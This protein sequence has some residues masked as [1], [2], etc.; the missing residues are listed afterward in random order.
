[1]AGYGIKIIH[2]FYQETDKKLMSIS[3]G[4]NESNDF[5]LMMIPHIFDLDFF[6]GKLKLI[7]ACDDGKFR[8]L[9]IDDNGNEVIINEL[10]DLFTLKKEELKPDNWK[11]DINI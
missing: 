2:V 8:E 10:E 4:K 5:I 11:K 3:F 9:L 6:M 7:A 1:M